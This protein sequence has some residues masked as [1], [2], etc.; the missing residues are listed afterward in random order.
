MPQG[1]MMRITGNSIQQR[2]KCLA[3]LVAE[4]LL[5]LGKYA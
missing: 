1:R 2:K 5:V 3:N 4:H